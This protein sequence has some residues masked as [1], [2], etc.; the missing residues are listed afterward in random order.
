[1]AVMHVGVVQRP[2][3]ILIQPQILGLRLAH[4]GQQREARDIG[5]APR[6]HQLHLCVDQFLLGVEDI[7]NGAVSDAVFG[8][9]A[10]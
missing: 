10:L 5:I 1:M 9:D 6:R 3:P 2:G 7:Q 4:R 8:P